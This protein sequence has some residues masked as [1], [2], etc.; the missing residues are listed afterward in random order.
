MMQS[1][2]LRTG[3]RIAASIA[4]L[5]VLFTPGISIGA[6]GP[7]VPKSI[8]QS[9]IVGSE[10]ESP[11]ARSQN[12]VTI[13]SVNIAGEGQTADI[14]ASWTQQRSL[15]V[16]LLQEVGH[17]STEGRTYIAQ[18]SE[19]MGVHYAYAPAELLENGHTHGLAI[20]SRFPL[21]EVQAQP[22][23]YHRLRFRSR[24][25]IALA[26]TVKTP[27]RPIRVVNVHLD[28]RI[29]TR[30]RVA[31]LTPVLDALHGFTGPSIVGGDFNTMNIRWFRTMWPFPYLQRQSSAVHAMFATAGFQTPLRGGPA[32]FR[33]LGLPLRLDWIF[34]KDLT[35]LEWGV[36]AVRF[37]DHRGVWASVTP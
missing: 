2:S 32:T 19:R 7:C 26:A 13:A 28:T 1:I 3:N 14:L 34:V 18:L 23:A 16:L 5:C 8:S 35:P 27:G 20:V 37:T 6:S 12:T 9:P 33:F 30:D 25:R 17:A 10:H 11:Q 15:D 24:C 21:D 22:L 29:N 4:V 31:Q 36:D